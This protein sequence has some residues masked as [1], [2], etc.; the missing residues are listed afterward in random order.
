MGTSRFPT[1]ARRPGRNPSRAIS[2]DVFVAAVR[3]AP[4]APHMTAIPTRR[5]APR[6]P[7]TGRFAK[8]TRAKSSGVPEHASHAGHPATDDEGRLP[9][10]AVTR[11]A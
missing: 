10:T 1:D 7:G 2:K 4:R 6:I 9:R 3:F 5:K 8:P 11:S